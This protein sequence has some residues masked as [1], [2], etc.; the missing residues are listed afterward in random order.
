MEGTQLIPKT[1]ADTILFS[2]PF[3]C[4]ITLYNPRV[5]RG[6]EAVMTKRRKGRKREYV[7]AHSGFPR[8]RDRE[9]GLYRRSPPD[10][11]EPGFAVLFLFKQ[12]KQ[13]RERERERERALFQSWPRNRRGRLMRAGKG[14]LLPVALVKERERDQYGGPHLM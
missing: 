1:S 9:M 5:R 2:F 10:T 4:Y 13:A 8:Q 14:Q 12:N 7:C 6:H 3:V 11:E